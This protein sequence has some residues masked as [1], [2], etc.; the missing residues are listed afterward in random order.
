MFESLTKKDA[1]NSFNDNFNKKDSLIGNLLETTCPENCRTVLKVRGPKEGSSSFSSKES[2]IR[3]ESESAVLL[4]ASSF[5][6]T[7]VASIPVIKPPQNEMGTIISLTVDAID[8]RKRACFEGS[9]QEKPRV[10]AFAGVIQQPQ[11]QQQ[12][13]Q[14]KRKIQIFEDDSIEGDLKG[15]AFKDPHCHDGNPNRVSSSSTVTTA[16]TT[17]SYSGTCKP[18]DQPVEN[19]NMLSDLSDNVLKSLHERTEF[20][21]V[22]KGK[23]DE[24]AKVSIQ[25][26]I[27]QEMSLIVNTLKNLGR[28]AMPRADLITHLMK[29]FVI[30][31]N[32]ALLERHLDLLVANFPDWCSITMAP[33]SN[34][35]IFRIKTYDIGFLKESFSESI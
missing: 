24:I 32:R 8:T 16:K 21:M 25:K 6:K 18:Q 5:G 20:Y 17:I 30:Q 13:S 28:L 3:K 27:L 11:Q 1:K 31:R 2:E 12:Q 14:K 15:V 34:K 4:T 29:D 22:H 33:M 26:E 23:S 35:P 9:S 10:S 7:S 19:H